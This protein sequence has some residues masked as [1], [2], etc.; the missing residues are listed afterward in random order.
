LTDKLPKSIGEVISSLYLSFFSKDLDDHSAKSVEYPRQELIEEKARSK[1]FLT[2]DT[3]MTDFGS[4]VV[5]RIMMS[6]LKLKFDPKS[7]FK[8]VE[9]NH[10]GDLGRM[11]GF[12]KPIAEKFLEPFAEVLQFDNRSSL[13]GNKNNIFIS[14]N[15]KSQTNLRVIIFGDS[16]F[17]E[18]IKL[19]SPIFKDILYIR[20]PNFHTDI[21]ELFEPDIVLTGNAERYLAKVTL[22]SDSSSPLFWNYGDKSYC[23]PKEFADAYS[24][25]L[26]WRHHRNFYTAWRHQL[27]K[28]RPW[29]FGSFGPILT[30]SQVRLI[31]P[32]KFSFTSNGSDPQIIFQSANIAANVKYKLKVSLVSAVDSVAKVYFTKSDDYDSKFSERN[33]V[34]VRVRVGMNQIMFDL[35]EFSLGSKIRLDP[36]SC[37]GD[38][39]LSD[40]Q[41]IS[42]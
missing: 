39:S 5:A 32:D 34:A 28:L 24:A 38:F 11:T 33:S 41:L 1:I 20:S 36:I 15:L 37:P 23:P 17:K 13:P 16:F 9:K 35:S 42:Y 4:L 3:H 21:I 19:L 27:E 22:D 10:L 14:S 29:S 31:D 8:V 6:R 30:N 26:S 2:Q 7:L 25:Q 40:L 12:R 18:L